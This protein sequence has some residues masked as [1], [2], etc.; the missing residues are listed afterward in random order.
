MPG[1]LTPIL[2]FIVIGFLVAGGM[3]VAAHVL[4]PS[5]STPVKQMP[6]ESG[7]D[8]IGDARGRFDIRYYLVAIVFLL[9]E[10][11]LVL[12]LP[13]VVLYRSSWE[14]QVLDVSAGGYVLVELLMFVGILVAGLAYIWAKGDLNWVRAFREGDKPLKRD[15]MP[16]RRRQ[17]AADAE[18]ESA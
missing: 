6:Y 3:L 1:T 5:K 11:E 2:L 16:R 14:V 4:G 8:P 18:G 17:A 13:L 12:T 10:V 7:M 15:L 9:F